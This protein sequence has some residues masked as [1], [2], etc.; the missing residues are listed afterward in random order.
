MNMGEHKHNGRV[1]TSEYSSHFNEAQIKLMEHYKSAAMLFCTISGIDPMELLRQPH[2]TVIGTEITMRAWMQ[3]V[4]H[5]NLRNREL[6]ALFQTQNDRLPPPP[7]TTAA[8]SAAA[9]P[10][11]A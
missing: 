11:A 6:I 3:H 2:P 10:P 8:E 7:P 1:A 5:L 4:D 9:E